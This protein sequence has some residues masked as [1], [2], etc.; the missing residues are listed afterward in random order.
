MT[1]NCES[2]RHTWMWED[3]K[4]CAI[5]FSIHEAYA[6]NTF[7]HRTRKQSSWK[8]S[9][10]KWSFK[11]WSGTL[12]PDHQWGHEFFQ[13]LKVHSIPWRDY[14]CDQPFEQRS[15]SC[16]KPRWPQSTPR[17]CRQMQVQ[18]CAPWYR[19]VPG[20]GYRW[21]GLRIPSSWWSVRS[22]VIQAHQRISPGGW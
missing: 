2:D 13:H 16:S 1:T 20:R 14:P 10:K 4:T 15:P 5:F 21:K 17:K 9:T 8:A 12:D 7:T 11:G 18:S 6:F 19:V 3:L 22:E